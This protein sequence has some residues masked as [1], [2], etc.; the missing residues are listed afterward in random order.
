MLVGGLAY[1]RVPRPSWVTALGPLMAVRR[2]PWAL[3]TGLAIAFVGLALL[4]W[5]WW[6]LRSLVVGDPLGVGRVRLAAGAWS[7]PLLVA[8]P[9]FSGDGWSYVATGYLGGHGL[10]PYVWT[11][12]VLPAA[13]RSGVNAHWL[14]TPTPYGPLPIAWGGAVSQLTADPWLLL[15]AYRVLALVGLGLVAWAAPRIAR[16][17]GLDPGAASW[18]AIASPFVIAHGVGGLHN[19]LLMAGLMLAALAVTHQDR[20]LLGAVL[21]GAAAAVKIPGGLIAV[22]VVLLSLAAGASLVQ[23]L[24]RTAAV[25]AVSAATLVGLGWVSGLGI[26]WVH[27]LWVPLDERTRLSVVQ[28]SGELVRRVLTDVVPAG[29][30]LHGLVHPVRFAAELGALT[31]AVLAGWLLLRKRTGNE[32]RV[33]LGAAGLMFAATLLSPV[34]HYWYALWCLPLLACVKLSRA[35]TA[36]MVA[37]LTILGLTA[38][39]D[40]SLHVTWLSTATAVAL[41]LVPISTWIVVSVRQGSPQREMTDLQA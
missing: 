33:L 1:A 30:T 16:R 10:S 15:I 23:R 9:L 25:G 32:P 37:A 26:G 17:C 27:A 40:P 11:P 24:R 36:A 22:G 18:G 20:W 38:M 41:L 31:V 13:L 3:G 2:A 12:S 34:A 21:A 19:D 7:L 5:A 39:A 4:T 28:L 6:E 35:Q 29:P 14:H 8:P